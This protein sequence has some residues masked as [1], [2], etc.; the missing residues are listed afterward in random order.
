MLD[1]FT[2]FACPSRLPSQAKT[3]INSTTYDADFSLFG[4]SSVDWGRGGPA[5]SGGSIRRLE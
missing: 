1:E 3:L 4:L 5:L 2:V